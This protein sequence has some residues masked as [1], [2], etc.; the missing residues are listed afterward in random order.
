MAAAP[1]IPVRD[2]ILTLL[3]HNRQ[4]LTDKEIA[5]KLGPECSPSLRV[6]AYN[7]LLKVRRVRLLKKSL[8]GGAELVVYQWVSARDAERMK[9][10]D[11]VTLMTY[12]L[13]KQA[14][15]NGLTKREIKLKTNIQS[16]SEIKQIVEWLISRDLV[17]EIKSVQGSNR[18]V[19]I[20]SEFEPSTAHTGGPWYNDDK[21]FD[22]EF[23]GIIYSQL[24]KFIRKSDYVTVPQVAAY[25]AELTRLKIFSE[26]LSEKDVKALVTTMLYDGVIQECDGARDGGDYFRF[27]DSAPSGNHLKDVPCGSCPVFHDCCPGGVISPQTCAY[28][29]DWLNQAW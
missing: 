19:F 4:G 27:V 18:K 20:A 17:K 9:G 28:M 23:I 7:E 29:T 22:T 14:K 16:A 24:L 3:E 6:G 15:Q 11:N 8:D 2:S 12:E 26:T 1:L 25:M 21:E 13:V 5:A 10:I